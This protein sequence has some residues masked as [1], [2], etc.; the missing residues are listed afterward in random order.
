MFFAG[1]ECS[2]AST[3]QEKLARLDQLAVW[4]GEEML[5]IHQR[6]IEGNL[7]GVGGLMG[8]WN[9]GFMG[10]SDPIAC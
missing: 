8:V 2:S 5:L 7:P 4:T 3:L 1:I 10:G 9:L 6:R